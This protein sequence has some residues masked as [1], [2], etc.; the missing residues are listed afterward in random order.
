MLFQEVLLDPLPAVLPTIEMRGLYRA[1]GEVKRV[2]ICP[3]G[4]SRILAPRGVFAPREMSTIDAGLES[5]LTELFRLLNT[6]VAI[7]TI[8]GAGSA[9][10][11]AFTEKPVSRCSP[12]V[13]P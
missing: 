11:A 6:R 9:A 2:V 8:S 10:G 12:V 1:V 13:S 5:L 4:G 3:C 7:P